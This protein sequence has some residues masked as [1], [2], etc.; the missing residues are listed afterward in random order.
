VQVP[1]AGAPGTAARVEIRGRVTVI[2]GDADLLVVGRVSV[3][4][5][6][7][8]P[9]PLPLPLYPLLRPRE[10]HPA[11]E[12]DEV[13]LPLRQTAHE[14][15]ATC[16]RRAPLFPL[17][18]YRRAIFFAFLAGGSSSSSSL[19]FVTSPAPGFV[20]LTSVS[21][22]SSPDSAVRFVCTVQMVSF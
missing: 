17:S 4:R 15:N 9:R 12:T 2:V 7:D 13:S 1:R 16:G 8:L 3:F 21:V 20:N 5:P 11:E 10:L 6:H 14:E 19:P 22:S 18:S